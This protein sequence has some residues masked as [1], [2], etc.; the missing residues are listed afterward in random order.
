MSVR[1]EGDGGD[2][3]TKASASWSDSAPC[4]GIKPSGLRTLP[5]F[6]RKQ[7]QKETYADVSYYL[8]SQ[9]QNIPQAR[10]N[11]FQGD[12]HRKTGIKGRGGT[13]A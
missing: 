6:P 7:K 12:S 9:K 1:R 13:N 8:L 2:A 4:H 5:S 3:V 11:S 10:D